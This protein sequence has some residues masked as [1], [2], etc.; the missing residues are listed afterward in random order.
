MGGD[1]K[2]TGP[3]FAA[4]VPF[5]G[6]PDGG[7]LAG[8]VGDEAVLLARRGNLVFAVGAACTHY[9]APLA[10]GVIVGETLRCPWHHAAFD[11]ATGEAVRPPA[12]NPLPCWTVERRGGAVVVTGRAGAAP[13]PRAL[14]PHPDRVVIV[15]AGAAG[16]A[17]AEMLRDLGF[18]GSL[19][20]LGA[21]PEPPYD[22]PNV[23]KD[24]LAGNAP[25]EWIPLRGPDLYAERRID[26]RLG[27]V[28][29]ALDLKA[30]RLSL[31]DG[32]ALGYDALLLATGADPI[33]LPIPG[34]DLP[35]VRTLRTL[36][37]S[38]Q[39]IAAAALARRAVVVGA[40]F[41][42][43]EVAASLRA[44]GLRVDV[45]APESVP[46]ERTLGAEVG[47]FVKTL[48]EEHGVVFHLGRKPV[49]IGKE[50]VELDDGASLPAGLVV[51]G[52]GV[53]PAVALAEAAG[54]A[55]DRG[56]V[57]DDTLRTSDPA[58][59]AAGDV[60]RYPDPRGGGRIR[61]E[62]WVVAQRQGRT[63][64]RNMLGLQE[65]FTAIPFF[66]SAHYD[67][68]IAYVGHAEGWDAVEIDGSFSARDVRVTYRRAGR[69]LAVATVGRD[70]ESLRA[71]LEF[72]AEVAR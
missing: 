8:R 11:L 65:R 47:A 66:W 19:T 37:D 64:A 56:V 42:G 1:V 10:D 44:R 17:A 52:V 48:H 46:L 12:L 59:F 20:L 62:H 72:E 14:G 16:H 28:A 4:G 54:L 5:E 13:R 2:A 41:I 60:A 50:S 58:V 32:A 7:V 3:D 71:E 49:A 45:V 68:T 22:R 21:D 30:R 69:T 36:A 23:S 70:L 29:T 53:R 67:V 35:H 25:E 6:V 43:L 40:S 38:R 27:V 55:F 39:L 33:R 31:S 34:A 15:G 24:Y 9:G 57:V 26:L 61:V 63:A 18:D 51:M